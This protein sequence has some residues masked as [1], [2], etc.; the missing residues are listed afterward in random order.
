VLGEIRRDLC[1]LG[2]IRRLSA[3]SAV[4]GVL[5]EIRRDLSV[6]GEICRLSAASP[7]LGVLGEIR[8]D[9]CVLGEIVV[10]RRPLRPSACSARSVVT[11][12]SSARSSSLGG[13]CG[14]RRPRRDPS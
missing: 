4:L 1:V 6:I 14:P 11:Y 2:E 9:L 3:A 13:L 5:G 10:S 8:R 7:V 12:A